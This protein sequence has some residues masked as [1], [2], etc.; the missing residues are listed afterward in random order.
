M[1]SSNVQTGGS[2]ARTL[3]QVRVRL[4]AIR[5]NT[6]TLAERFDGHLAAV[7][8]GVAGDRSVAGAMLDGGAD[9]LADSRI[10]NLRRLDRRYD[11]PLLLLRPPMTGDLEAVASVADYSIHTEYETLARLD[12]AVARLDES[13]GAVVMVDIGDR[14]EGV[15]PEDL[16]AVLSR[17][18]ELS[19]V[20]V[21]GIGVNFACMNGLRA[22]ER[23]M[24]Q[25]REIRALAES[26]LERHLD[27]VSIGG[28]A[29]VPRL[30]DGT[31]LA[32]ITQVRLGEAILLGREPTTDTPIQSLRQDGFEVVTQVVEQKTKPSA[33]DGETAQTA[34]GERPERTGEGT[35]DRAIVALG[36]QDVDPS[37]LRPIRDDVSVVGASSDH[38]VLNVTRSDPP[39][40]V[41][42]TVRFAPGYGSLLQVFTS[43][44]VRPLYSDG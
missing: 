19:A 33:P 38:T 6:T 31:D 40:T 29:V 11:V 37:A 21:A 12:A 44:Y 3:P 39:V 2:D 4:D 43:P 36:R 22:T 34:F 7:T 1:V 10:D 26:T 20:D 17:M 28:S 15:L 16:P 32:G 24:S 30:D 35:Q 14:R 41:G 8:K 27:V 9:L 25:V 18:D 5:E 23:K 42:D 13:H